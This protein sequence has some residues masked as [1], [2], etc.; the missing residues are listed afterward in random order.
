MADGRSIGVVVAVGGGGRGDLDLARD[1]ANG[2]GKEW[3]PL[4]LFVE[5]RVDVPGVVSGE[6]VYVGGGDSMLTE[7]AVVVVDPLL[8]ARVFISGREGAMAVRATFGF[9]MWLPSLL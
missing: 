5:S 3:R 1:K 4:L 7:V 9:T 8:E 2:N 6:Q